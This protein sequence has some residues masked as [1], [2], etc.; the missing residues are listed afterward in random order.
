MLSVLLFLID[1]NSWKAGGKRRTD[2]RG[3]RVAS[4]RVG[5]KKSAI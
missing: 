4:E 2:A 1:I 3:G 5:T